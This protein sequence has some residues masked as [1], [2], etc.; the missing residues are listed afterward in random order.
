MTLPDHE[1]RSYIIRE[2]FSPNKEW[3]TDNPVLHCW[4][5]NEFFTQV[6]RLIE[7]IP[8]RINPNLCDGH[9]YGR[10]SLLILLTLLPSNGTLPFEFIKQFQSKIEF[11]YQ[12]IHGRTAAHYAVILGRKDLLSTLVQH[13]AYLDISDEHGLNPLDYINCPQALIEQTLKT[14]DIEPLRDVKASRNRIRDQS[15]TPIRMK[16]NLI[17]QTKEEADKLLSEPD[18]VLVKYIEGREPLWS[19]FIGDDSPETRICMLRLA[20]TISEE[21]SIPLKEIF[22]PSFLCKEELQ[23]FKD[24]L[25]SLSLDLSGVS[26]IDSCLQGHQEILNDLDTLIHLQKNK[27]TLKGN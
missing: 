4:L 23:N 11:N 9:V 14:I 6:R 24:G 19:S 25:T 8:E 12:D 22:I 17:I 10:K 15:S 7:L 16:G 3:C 26:M 27:R 21:L 13:G 18:L 20:Q 2:S 1:L 5:A